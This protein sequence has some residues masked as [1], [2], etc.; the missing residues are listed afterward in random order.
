MLGPYLK[1]AVT[2]DLKIDTKSKEEK[3][4]VALFFS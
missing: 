2:F 3:R 4:K 1:K